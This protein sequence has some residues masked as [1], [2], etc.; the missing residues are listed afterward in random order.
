VPVER[1]EGDEGDGEA[2]RDLRA[3]RRFARSGRA[4]YD[5]AMHASEA[6]RATKIHKRPVVT[7]PARS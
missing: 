1:V 6:R 2:L 3:E 7:A 4:D 5:D